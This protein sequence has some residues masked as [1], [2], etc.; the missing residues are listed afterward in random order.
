MEEEDEDLV[1]D[2]EK[3]ETVEPVLNEA[4]ELSLNLMVGISTP[5]T[6]KLRGQIEG[7]EVVV[8]IDCG[9]SHN[10]ISLDLV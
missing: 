4:A 5:K 7:Q 9:T 2:L 3:S 1:P 8:L 6:M 10:F